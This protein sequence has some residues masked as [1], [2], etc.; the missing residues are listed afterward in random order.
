MVIPKISVIIPVYNVEEY[1][2]ECLDSLL[3]QTFTD[4]EAVCVDDGSTDRSSD[5]LGQYV[6]RDE[7]IRVI[8]QENEGLSCARNTGIDNA[9]GI[10][11]IFFDADDL[12][13][14]TALET[15]WSACCFGEIDIVAFENDLKSDYEDDKKSAG[16]ERFYNVKNNY[17]G[18]KTGR[19]MFCEKIEN[20]DYVDSACLL[21][22][23]K[24]W[25]IK[26]EIRFFPHALYED[27]VFSL[28][29]YFRCER[30][31]HLHKKLYI[32]RLRQKSITTSEITEET[33]YHR[34]WHIIEAGYFLINIATT[35]RERN[36]LVSF[37]QERLRTVR[38]EACQISKK[39]KQNIS[40]MPADR[41][42]AL[43]IS[44][45]DLRGEANG[46]H[47]RLDGLIH[48]IGEFSGI[49]LYGAGIVGKK[50]L[51][52]LEKNGLYE[53]VLGF[54]VTGGVIVKEVQ[55]K[56]VK[57]LSEYD[58]NSNT[59]VLVTVAE[60]AHDDVIRQIEMS[61]FG[62]FYAIDYELE[63]EIDEVLGNGILP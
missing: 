58:V 56:P 22:I 15:L 13:C 52:Y 63:S 48:K 62:Y 25:L 27:S 21:F 10:Y 9:K 1:L 30:M 54:A 55:G 5:V 35:E 7:R 43:R 49:I 23:K 16:R 11:I 46:W 41:Q 61:G 47:L 12:L 28:Y 60:R 4:F 18:V 24:E 8:R 2:E 44:G 50:T 53:K 42:L 26:R 34:I 36:A 39:R 51:K 6:L 45:V 14:S 38:V 17:N 31:L 40:H 37:I 59:L 29:C 20:D 19:E 32:Y 33:V 57:K 3:N